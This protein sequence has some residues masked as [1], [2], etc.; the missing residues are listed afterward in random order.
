MTRR[1]K[2]GSELLALAFKI[3][4]TFASKE[5]DALID[6]FMVKWGPKRCGDCEWWTHNSWCSQ[7]I[8]RA[9]TN[10]FCAIW[11]AP[12]TNDRDSCAK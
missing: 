8:S 4:A 2:M 12:C 5:C 6:A 1:E 7:G 3:S 11:E 9:D 10:F